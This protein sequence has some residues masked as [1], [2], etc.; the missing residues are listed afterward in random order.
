MT[1]RPAF[2]ACSISVAAR[3]SSI[4]AVITGAASAQFASKLVSCDLQQSTFQ[5]GGFILIVLNRSKGT[6]IHTALQLVEGIL[7]AL[8]L[9]GGKQSGTSERACMGA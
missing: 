5:R 3:P 7:H 1:V 8:Q 4:F 9:V 6:G 2:S